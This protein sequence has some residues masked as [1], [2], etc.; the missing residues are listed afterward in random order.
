MLNTKIEELDLS[1]LDVRAQKTVRNANIANIFELLILVKMKNS[2][3]LFRNFGVKAKESIK[4][5][6][7]KYGID[8]ENIP[9]D[10][11]DYNIGKAAVERI[12]QICNKYRHQGPN[13]CD[14]YFLYLQY[15]EIMHINKS[16]MPFLKYPLEKNYQDKNNEKFIE[17]FEL[18][19]DVLKIVVKQI[20]EN[21]FTKEDLEENQTPTNEVKTK[22][23]LLQMLKQLIA[24]NERLREENAKLNST[25]EEFISNHK[26][27]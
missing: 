1:K 4:K 5:T 10:L 17:D 25:L 23:E 26:A 3:I 18:I 22:S 15:S 20:E 21:N 7:K 9:Y 24:E 14:L 12:T 11:K 8:V 16:M 27:K 2:H 6:L 13:I 19:K